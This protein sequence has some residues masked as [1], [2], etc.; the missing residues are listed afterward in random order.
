[1]RCIGTT[2][3]VLTG[4]ERSQTTSAVSSPHCHLSCGPGDEIVRFAHRTDTLLDRSSRRRDG[5]S[6]RSRRS[7]RAPPSRPPAEPRA[8]ARQDAW[9]SRRSLDDWRGHQYLAHDG[10]SSRSPSSRAPLIDGA[11]FEPSALAATTAMA[12]CSSANR[13][14]FRSMR[15]SSR[16]VSAIVAVERS[17]TPAISGRTTTYPIKP[18]GRHSPLP[19]TRPKRLARRGRVRTT[20]EFT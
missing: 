20:T 18:A 17:L 1:M 11:E 5:S 15:T 14:R 13:A 8:L 3:G 10:S 12:N 19:A 16:V 7:R 2:T 9:M 4:C 6:D